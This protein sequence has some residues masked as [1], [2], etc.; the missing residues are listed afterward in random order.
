[1]LAG[2]RGIKSV[3]IEQFIERWT[4]SDYPPE[5]VSLSDLEA[6]ERELGVRLPTQYRD[7]I[8]R[9]GA[10]RPTIA[11]LDSIVDNDLGLH[12]VSDFL[13]P[14]ELVKMTFAARGAGMPQELIAFAIDCMGNMFCFDAVKLQTNA[15]DQ[16]AIWFFDH[17]F[18]TVEQEAPD[19]GAWIDRF[20][21]VEPSAGAMDDDDD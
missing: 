12:D 6:A 15:S 10:P 1:M 8:V 9:A 7:A 2:N 11:L 21:D 4:H 18:C 16:Q 13:S 3:G 20:C 17:D 14:A 5:S 19:F